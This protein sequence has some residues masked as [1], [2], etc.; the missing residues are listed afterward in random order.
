MKKNLTNKSGGKERCV[1]VKKED[2]CTYI[3]T[4]V[5]FNQ[6]VLMKDVPNEFEKEKEKLA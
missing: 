6:S 1:F 2:L 4:Y 5:K 3:H